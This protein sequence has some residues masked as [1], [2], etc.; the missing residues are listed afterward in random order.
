M[1]KRALD[2]LWFEWLLAIRLLL[3]GRAQSLLIISGIGVG[4]CVIVFLTALIGGLQKQI[5]DRTLGTQAHIRVRPPEEL[6]RPLRTEADAEAGL[7]SQVDQRAQRL[8][9]LDQWQRIEQSLLAADDITA[10]SPLASG[11]ALARRGAASRSVVILGIEPERYTR[12]VPVQDSL[13][14]GRFAIVGNDIAIGRQLATELGAR[15]GDRLRLDAGD[16]R[17]DVFT[18]VGIFELGVRDIDQRFVY[19]ALKPAQALLDLP[20]GVSSLDLRVTEIFAAEPIAQRISARLGVNAE[21]WMT[22][23]RNVLDALSAQSMSTNLIK[24]FVGLSAAFGIASVLAVSVVQRGREIGI[25]RA[26]GTGR[27]QVLRVF[28]I[29]GGVVGLLGSALGALGGAG[30]IGAWSAAGLSRSGR[31][32]F[33]LAVS[34]ELFIGATLLATVV[35]MLAAV[36]PARRAAKLDPVEAMRGG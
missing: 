28:L 21:S 29:Q 15:L 32:S 11:P 27:G 22:L 13:Q 26:M 34:P 10:V 31:G 6:A 30:L 17:A 5:I 12:I 9:A 19:T 23:N 7:I 16:G 8:R 4:V 33:E 20:G 25:L 2:S 3:E 1:L 24:F 36:A 35:G 18:I 14:E